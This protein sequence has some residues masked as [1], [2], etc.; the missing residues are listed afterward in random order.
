MN[1]QLEI[2]VRNSIDC[3]SM[4]RTRVLELV[5]NMTGGNIERTCEILRYLTYEYEPTKLPETIENEQYPDAKLKS[6]NIY[7]DEVTFTYTNK[8]VRYYASEA[9]A[10]KF[11]ETGKSPSWR[12]SEKKYDDYQFEA[13][14]PILSEVSISKTSWLNYANKKK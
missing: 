7:R 14:N 12:Y 3:A 1:T 13:S 11:T 9:D 2:M 8:R 10:Q 5:Q 4:D 6:Y